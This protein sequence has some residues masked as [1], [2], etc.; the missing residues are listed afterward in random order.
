MKVHLV[1]GTYELFRSWFGAPEARSARGQEVGATR[2][3]LRSMVALLRDEE[4]TH[5]ACAFD[6]TVESFRNE[7]FEGYK[8]GEG[9][10]PE[11]LDQFPLVERASRA[12]GMVTWPMVELEA[13]DALASAAAKFRDAPGVEQIVICSP[14]KD[15]CQ[16]VR[17]TDVVTFDRRRDILLDAEG[18]RE[19]FGVPPESIPDYLALVGDDADGI[20]GIARWGPKSASLVLAKLSHLENIPDEHE[21]WGV[22]VRGAATLARNL[23]E[24][25]DEAILYRTLATLRTDAPIAESLDDLRWTGPDRPALEALCEELGERALLGRI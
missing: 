4:V 13:D 20:P 5:V 15:L 17:R 7:L 25:R 21:R 1:D 23:S 19:K 16:C 8:T 22:S 3:F 9:L 14:D 10:E 18:V 11:L 6:Q 24:R 2:G 12:L